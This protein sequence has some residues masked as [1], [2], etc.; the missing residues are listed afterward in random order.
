MRC[1]VTG[2]TGFIGGRLVDA[3]VEDGHEVR[4]LV[5][6]PERASLLRRPG[7]ELVRGDLAEPGGLEEAVHGASHVFHCAGLVGDWLRGDEA[8][9]VNV[10]GTRALMAACAA[11]GVERVVY[12]SSLSI[13]GL[14]HH[15]G[16]DETAPLRY[17][18]EPY[19][20]SKIDAER[21]V[22]VHAGRPGP[23]V[24]VLRP[25]FVYGPGD[26]RFLPTL[27]DAL[28]GGRFMYVGDGRKLLNLSYVDDVAWGMLLAAAEPA[29]VGQAYNLT[30]GTK[31]SLREFVEF[32]CRQLGIPVPTRRIPPPVA[33]A[34]CRVA[35]AVARARRAE[36]APRLSRG[37][38]RFLHY[39]QHYSA[40]KAR[41]ELGYRPRFTYREGIT[42]TLV[43][44][45][46]QGLLPQPLV[47]V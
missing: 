38:M 39:N 29:A 13:Y 26:R 8:R 18:G 44:Y 11:T 15:H 6:D 20:D 4:A 32:I 35:E 27:L 2:A 46:E 9:R 7:V 41:R 28:A 24:V 40:E 1:F 33:F 16:T 36:V 45:R 37:R 22:W 47:A 14:C 42:S 43:W 3:L 5:R 12:L 10:E 21:M 30:D 23:D 25:G 19:I 34:A 17:C 31:T